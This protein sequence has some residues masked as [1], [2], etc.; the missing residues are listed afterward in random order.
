MTAPVCQVVAQL[1]GVTTQGRDKPSSATYPA[2]LSTIRF[3][4]LRFRR[5][6]SAISNPMTSR[7][8]IS[9]LVSPSERP[10]SRSRILPSSIIRRKSRWLAFWPSISFNL[11]L[12]LKAPILFSVLSRNTGASLP[13]RS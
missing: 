4:S 3:H 10:R 7:L 11:G 2:N 6:L 12:R 5:R 1:L 8:P 13:H 9:R